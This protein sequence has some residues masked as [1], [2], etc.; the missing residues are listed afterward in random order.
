MEQN[1][2][3]SGSET[4]KQMRAGELPKPS[5][6]HEFLEELKLAGFVLAVLCVFWG[7]TYL[8]SR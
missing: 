8:Q 6:W 5:K 3:L 2:N 1:T 4:E 7:I